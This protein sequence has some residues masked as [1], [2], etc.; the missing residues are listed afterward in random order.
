M[1]CVQCEV[2]VVQGL[3]DADPGGLAA[4]EPGYVLTVDNLL[5]MLSIAMRLRYDL[6][7]IIMGETGCGKSTLARQIFIGFSFEISNALHC[8]APALRPPRHHHGR[9]RLRKEYVFQNVVCREGRAVV[10]IIR[11]HLLSLCLCR[12]CHRR[13]PVS[14]S[15]VVVVSRCR[16][17]HWGAT[18]FLLMLLARHTDP[19]P[20]LHPGG[21]AAHPECARWHGGHG[22]HQVDGG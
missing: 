15:G 12:G 2:V 5:K 10:G 22:R 7:V 4:L 9:D 21:A 18:D 16:A 11:G 3:N 19:Q 8:H 14:I 20:V 6:P 1:L 17:L 13:H